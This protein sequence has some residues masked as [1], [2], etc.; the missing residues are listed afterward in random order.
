M[1]IL[2]KIRKKQLIS[3]PETVN[4]N[5]ASPSVS[6][7]NREGDFSIA[8]KYENGISV[9]M[10][11]YIQLSHDDLDFGDIAP[12][13]PDGTPGD[14]CIEIIDSSGVC[15]FDL[16]GSGAE[17]ARLRVEVITGSIDV[18]EIKYTASQRH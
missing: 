18:V 10:K 5:W 13:N 7:D 2:D 11:V 17:F 1:G 12:T 6:L 14:G 3:A 9:H 8:L 16:G 15:L 4:T